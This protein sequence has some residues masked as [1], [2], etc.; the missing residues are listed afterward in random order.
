MQIGT[1]GVENMLITSSIRYE[2]VEG[3]EN[4]KQAL[5]KKDSF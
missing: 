5:K 2:G 4:K 3:K 1:Q